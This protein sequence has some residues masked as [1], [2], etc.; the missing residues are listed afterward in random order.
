VRSNPRNSIRN[1]GSSDPSSRMKN[2]QGICLQEGGI[3]HNQLHDV[4]V[5]P[6]TANQK[7]V[8]DSSL[9]REET[10]IIGCFVAFFVNIVYGLDPSVLHTPS[11]LCQNAFG[12]SLDVRHQSAIIMR[13]VHDDQSPFVHRVEGYFEHLGEFAQL[14]VVVCQRTTSEMR[15]ASFGCIAMTSRFENSTS[16]RSNLIRELRAAV[17]T[18]SLIPGASSENVSVSSSSL[19]D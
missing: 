6:C 19:F 4:R 11:A 5:K 7:L 3:A 15:E 2:P 17:A 18:S 1:R 13:F 16:V 8:T 14:S 10:D 12:C 9:F